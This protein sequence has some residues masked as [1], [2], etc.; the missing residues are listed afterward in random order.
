MR[1]S[2]KGRYGT[3]IMVRLAMLAG[4]GP[5]TKQEI[6]E[7]EGISADYVEQLL[8]KLR[9][10]GL[11]ESRRGVRGGFVLARDPAQI[12]VADVLAATEGPI[13]IAPCQERRCKRASA[14]ATQSVWNEATTAL[15]AVFRA[16]TVQALAQQVADLEPTGS[17]ASG[18]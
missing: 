7:S 11:V 4:R 1:L 10:A 8:T 15:N 9:A 18:I 2:T 12:T 6:A 5:S 17:F 14:C 13:R 3:R 16:R